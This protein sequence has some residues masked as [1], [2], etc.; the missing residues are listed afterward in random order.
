[1]SAWV[2]T[3]EDASTPGRTP[4]AERAQPRTSPSAAT[5]GNNHPGLV[6]TIDELPAS[7]VDAVRDLLSSLHQRESG[8]PLPGKLA[9][10]SALAGEGVS[11]ISH[12]AAAVLVHDYR[13]RVCLVDLNWNGTTRQKANRRRRRA[14]GRRNGAAPAAL[15]GLADS[16]R[17][18]LLRGDPLLDGDDPRQQTRRAISLRELCCETADPRLT[19]VDAGVASQAEGQVFARSEQLAQVV[20]ALARHHDR[21]ILDLPPVLASTA[22]TPLARMADAVVVVVRH[23]VTT[24][25]QVRA[26]LDR[27]SNIDVAGVVLNRASSKIPGPLRR[28]LANW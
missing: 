17:R 9:F 14:V 10:T 21:L 2:A 26:T 16:L 23:G 4:A 11:Y 3:R 25:S 20:A 5:A 7:A 22:A 27:L 28:R 24:E 12:A 15:P 13:Q 8:R 18:E 1:M 6:K 19:Y